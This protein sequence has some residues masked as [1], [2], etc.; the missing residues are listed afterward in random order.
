MQ[1]EFE[2]L[3][4]DIIVGIDHTDNVASQRVLEK[5]G[6]RFTEAKEYFGMACYR[7]AIERR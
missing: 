2:K 5:L 4:L 6:M 3:D 7:Y 1:N